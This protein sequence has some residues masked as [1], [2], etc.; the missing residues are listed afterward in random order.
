MRWSHWELSAVACLGWA[1]VI[2]P[3]QL[4]GRQLIGTATTEIIRPNPQSQDRHSGLATTAWRRRRA[5]LSR[6]RQGQ[7]RLLSV[8]RPARYPLDG[9][10]TWPQRS[11]SASVRC[12]VSNGLVACSGIGSVS[13]SGPMTRSS[14][15]HCSPHPIS[16]QRRTLRRY[17]I[18]EWLARHPP[19]VFHLWEPTFCAPHW[20]S[21]KGREILQK[22]RADPYTQ[23]ASHG[24]SRAG[25]NRSEA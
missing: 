10:R 16:L 2:G 9:A 12:C 22:C 20:L 23:G 5:A 21:E 1:K 4:I 14:P 25:S 19:F 11:G 7:P 8:A 24:F 3:W 6:E 18:L 17:H 13:S 15:P